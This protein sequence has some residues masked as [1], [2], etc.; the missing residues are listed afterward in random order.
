MTGEDPKGS[1]GSPGPGRQALI[2][3]AISVVAER[4][5]RGLTYRAVAEQAGVTHALVTHYFGSRDA[6]IREALESTVRSAE[7][8]LFDDSQSLHEFAAPLPEFVERE[9]QLLLFQYELIFESLRRPELVD[10]IHRMYQDVEN[11]AAEQLSRHG[12]PDDNGALQRLI[13]A[14]LDGLLLR[15]L[16]EGDKEKTEESLTLLREML[17]LTRDSPGG[18]KPKP[19]PKR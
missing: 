12:I 7:R 16:V 19:K 8:G 15:Q 9:S 10:A 14:A 4:G 13:V 2:D 5:L 6:F 1:A 18:S 3:A 11:S 17:R